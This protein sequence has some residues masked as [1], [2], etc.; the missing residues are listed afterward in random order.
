MST[1]IL[2]G[3]FELKKKL[4]CTDFR[5]VYLAYDRHYI[6]RPPCEVVVIRYRQREIRHRLERQ[7]QVLDRL[8][9]AAAVPKLL[10]YFY[11]EAAREDNSQ[12]GDWSTLEQATDQSNLF[13][14]VQQHIA[15]YPLSAELKSGNPLS[16]SYVSQLLRDVLASLIFIHAQGVV[17]QNLHPQHLLRRSRDGQIF[18]THFASLSRLA[19][20][21]VDEGGA[22]VTTVPVGPHPYTA[23]EQLQPDY[24]QQLQP[25]SDLYALGLIAIE[26]LTGRPHYDFGYDP[27][28][29][30]QWRENVDVSPRLAEFIDRLVR[31]DW[32]DRFDSAAQALDTL[33]GVCDRQRIAKN[34]YLPTIIAAPGVGPHA[35]HTQPGS[36]WQQSASF[37]RNGS[38]TRAFSVAPVA[39]TSSSAK[40][41]PLQPRLLKLFTASIAVLVALGISV[42]T[43]QWG[44]YRLTR[45]PETWQNRT[46]S[47]PKTPTDAAM[48]QQLSYLLAD[49]SILLR[50][51]AANAY[52]DMVA[53]AQ[54]G[55][56]EL[57]ALSGYREPDQSHGS[58]ANGSLASDSLA[59]STS[60]EVVDD[61]H[62]GYAIDIGGREEATDRQ[63]SFTETDAF[64]WLK[65]NA[66]LYGFELSPRKQGLTGSAS[67]EPWHWRYRPET[68]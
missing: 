51:E 31:Q 49:G 20:S 27:V 5:T 29:G 42:K 21:E 52:W 12:L 22:L 62:T 40:L 30:L 50:T 34:S 9:A 55:G 38:I 17:H 2:Q 47:E 3:R 28:D 26:A 39:S 66:H 53:A 25:A 6:Q 64:R 59:D 16:E 56:I 57:Y 68:D 54:S 37:N 63:P 44:Q 4:V 15:G 46:P 18:L 36:S 48:P 23:P 32:R 33:S 67:P 65:A 8:S 58:K 1:R 13:Y 35:S 24:D 11:T 41:R 14:L 43:Y 61:Y 45:L 7:A 19:R 60:S 10:A